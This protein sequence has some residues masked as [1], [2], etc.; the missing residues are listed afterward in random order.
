MPTDSDGKIREVLRTWHYNSKGSREVLL[1]KVQRLVCKSTAKSKL[2]RKIRELASNMQ[3]REGG[4]TP[5]TAVRRPRIRELQVED[6]PLEPGNQNRDQYDAL[7]AKMIHAQNSVL[8]WRAEHEWLIEEYNNL[9]HELEAV[10]NE[11]D[12]LKAWWQEQQ[13]VVNISADLQTR[14]TNYL[15]NGRI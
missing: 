4:Q 12:Q 6:P 5:S 3:A 14:V 9:K 8:A 10:K 2:I 7:Y 13:R 11:R 1:Q 15:S